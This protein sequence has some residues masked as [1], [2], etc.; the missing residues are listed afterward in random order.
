MPYST[1]SCEVCTASFRPRSARGA[2]GAHILAN[3]RCVQCRSAVEDLVDNYAAFRDGAVAPAAE[4][5]NSSAGDDFMPPLIQGVFDLETFGLDRGWGV[6][7]VFSM[8]VHRGGAPVWI[9]Y[10]LTMSPTWPDE[11]SNDRWLAEKALSAL[12]ECHVLYAHNGSRFDIPWLRTLALKYNLPFPEKKLVDPCSVAWKKYRVGSNSLS[13]LAQFLG[14]AESKMPVGPEVWRTA[15]FDN[16]LDSWNTLRERCKSDV[17]LL[18]AVASRV[19][20]DVGMI[21]N[22]GSAW[23]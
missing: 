23:R 10:D 8:M 11:R 7:M 5:H 13:S 3:K 4:P 16:N 19:T 18:N 17:R 2:R 21:D 14:L 22:G 6:L 15:L 20:R 1:R 12:S 9:N